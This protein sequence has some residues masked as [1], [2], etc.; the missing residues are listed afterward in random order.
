MNK[1]TFLV[2]L[3]FQVFPLVCGIFIALSS[4]FRIDSWILDFFSFTIFFL[5]IINFLMFV[6]ALWKWNK[7]QYYILPYLVVFMSVKPINETVALNFRPEYVPSH[8][9]V[10]SY[11]IATFNTERMKNY[12]SDSL[13]NKAI[14]DWLRNHQSP[15]ILCI[16]E[17]YHSDRS[18]SDNTLDS[19]VKIGKYKYYY[20]NPVYIEKYDGFF[21]VITFSKY[22][23]INSGEIKF[24][25]KDI[26]RGIYHD[27]DVGNDTIR[28]LNFQLNSMS[29]RT[30]DVFED[31]HFMIKPFYI[32]KD[33]YS[34]LEKGY[35]KR[36]QELEIISD[37]ISISPYK[38]IICA[39]LNAIPNSE[40]YQTLKSQFNNAFERAGTG[41]GFT[42]HHFPWFI[43]IDHQFYD[44]GLRINYF[45]VHKDFSASD[46]YP[47]EA[48]YDFVD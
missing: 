10:M 6:F 44:K 27:F 30:D 20:T 45:K 2:K 14:F 38:I 28:I 31:V 26:N 33:I 18:E 36:R 46:H 21:G 8:L 24:G 25:G 16:Q 47:I 1:K 9:S 15:D 5:I 32:L 7:I 48:G 19:I 34:K 13:S 17:F 3:L 43:R 23:S 42:Y 11:N 12:E 29:I 4:Y 22:S 41:F 39:D 37:F 40:T 35:Y